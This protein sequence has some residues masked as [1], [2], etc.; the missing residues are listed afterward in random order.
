MKIRA[1][2]AAQE[3]LVDNLSS[4]FLSK[5][6]IFMNSF[7]YFVFVS[8][9]IAYKSPKSPLPAIRLPHS[10]PC[11]FEQEEFPTNPLPGSTID[12]AV[13]K[14]KFFVIQADKFRRKRLHEAK[15]D[16]EKRIEI[17]NKMGFFVFIQYR[18]EKNNPASRNEKAKKH[19][20]CTQV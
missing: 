20:E 17:H 13:P 8:R 3:E 16:S 14:G 2:F 11:L 10:S 9:I 19:A 18:E 5:T 6:L 12:E 15:P 7:G 4:V 1:V